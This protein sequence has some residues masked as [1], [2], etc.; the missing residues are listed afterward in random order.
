MILAWTIL[1]GL[2]LV[3]GVL[4]FL[5]FTMNHDGLG[6]AGFIGLAAVGICGWGIFA[7]VYDVEEKVQYHQA[8]SPDMRYFNYGNYLFFSVDIA[9]DEDHFTYS[10]TKL[11]KVKLYNSQDWVVK[12]V[13]TY[14]MYGHLDDKYFYL[15]SCDEWENG[16]QQIPEN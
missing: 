14:N 2:T 6:A 4:L 16:V 3:C 5:G 1:I 7:S 8:D 12:I 9:D 13:T 10:T 11:D 15:I